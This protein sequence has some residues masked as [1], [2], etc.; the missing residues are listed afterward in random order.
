MGWIIALGVILL[1][2][3]L[4]YFTRAELRISSDGEKTRIGVYILGKKIAP[5]EKKKT[6][7]TQ[8]EVK[9]EKSQKS[10]TSEKVDSIKVFVSPFI[11]AAKGIK[12]RLL[13]SELKLEIAVSTD[14]AAKT[15]IVFGGVSA[16]AGTLYGLLKNN[17]NIRNERIN[18]FPD[19]T[20]TKSVIRFF[21][22]FK[23]RLYDFIAIGIKLLFDYLKSKRTHRRSAKKEY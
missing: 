5:S 17:F 23:L 21:C 8:T 16:A 10:S 7:E 14:D 2:F 19:F 22:V 6:K 11:N 4:L 12:K 3:S 20:Q 13:I 18:I 15:A 9:V 1:L